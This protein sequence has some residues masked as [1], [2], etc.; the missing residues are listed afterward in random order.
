MYYDVVDVK[1]CNST[2]QNCDIVDIFIVKKRNEKIMGGVLS[3]YHR[4]RSA[5]GKLLRLLL[6]INDPITVPEPK[7]SLE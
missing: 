6:C 5:P 2:K 1:M 3:S 4:Q 7:N